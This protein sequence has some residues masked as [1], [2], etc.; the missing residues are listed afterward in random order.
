MHVGTAA[1]D[2]AAVGAAEVDRSTD[3]EMLH[4]F[5]PCGSYYTHLE[6]MERVDGIPVI[7]DQSLY[8]ACVRNRARA[9]TRRVQ[10]RYEALPGFFDVLSE[11]GSPDHVGDRVAEVHGYPH[12]GSQG[13][14]RRIYEVMSFSDE[15][16]RNQVPL[17]P[18]HR[19][20]YTNA[21][22]FPVRGTQTF[23]AAANSFFRLL[24]NRPKAIFLKHSLATDLAV[25]FGHDAG[26][27][28][29]LNQLA[30]VASDE[31]DAVD[32]DRS[33]RMSE[34]PNPLWLPLSPSD[35]RRAADTR[36]FRNRELLPTAW[37]AL[38]APRT[39][40]LYR[41]LL[42]IPEWELIMELWVATPVVVSYLAD[43]LRMARCAGP[44]GRSFGGWSS[45]TFSG[46]TPT[47]V[48][49]GK[50]SSWSMRPRSTASAYDTRVSTFTGRRTRMRRYRWRK[51]P[52]ITLGYG[53]VVV[54]P[55]MP[56]PTPLETTR[57]CHG[58][59]PEEY[60]HAIYPYPLRIRAEDAYPVCIMT[61]RGEVISIL[62][63]KN[64]EVISDLY[65]RYESQDTGIYNIMKLLAPAE[66]RIRSRPL[67]SG[68][69]NLGIHV[70]T[71]GSD[72]RQS[73]PTRKEPFNHVTRPACVF[74]RV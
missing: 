38:R 6:P 24:R 59:I 7:T 58:Y 4:Q 34:L 41:W 39:F 69:D 62:S 18:F 23:E 74:I 40:D 68:S 10:A 22:F 63:D 14:Q 50:C 12:F 25:P 37:A 27:E 52:R 53:A 66:F 32:V 55:I 1:D 2:A 67:F 73:C 16:V 5:Q 54:G 72:K 15:I 26:F 21:L 11:P 47:L 30:L 19:L 36:F 56:G 60:I 45:R 13:T 3:P 28:D 51:S 8:D 70:L 64:C 44:W 57:G 71:C 31:N 43:A 65:P 20:V 35:H 61:K 29:F 46:A 33:P 17:H 48:R 9:H 49:L 42:P